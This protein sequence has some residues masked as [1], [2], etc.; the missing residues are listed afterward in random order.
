LQILHD[1][2][3]FLLQMAS[4]YVFLAGVNVIRF[5]IQGM[6][7]SAFAILSGVFEMVARTLVGIFVVPKFGFISAGTADPLAWIFA[8]IFLLPAFVLCL[9]KLKKN[10]P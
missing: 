8:D 4:C 2:K 3:I 5:T 6:G 7:F 1:A 10:F 9:K